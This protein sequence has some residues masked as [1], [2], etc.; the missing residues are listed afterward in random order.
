MNDKQRV[1]LA[2]KEYDNL[3]VKHKIDVDKGNISVGSVSQVNDKPSGEQSFVITDQYVSPTASQAE[4]ESVKEVTVLYRGS[5]G[6]DKTLEK[7]GDVYRD[8]VVN[9]SEMAHKILTSEQGN[10]PPQLV[11]SAETLKEA[12]ELYPNANFS[13]Y[14][15]SLGSMNAQYAV[16]DLSLEDSQRISGGYFFQGPNIYNVLTFG[17]QN[18]ATQLTDAG[19]LYNYVDDKDLVPIGYGDGKLSVGRLIPVLSK[20]VDLTAQHMWGG[21]QYD[22]FGNVLLD[23]KGKTEI[24]G[25]ETQQRISGLEGLK[26]KFLANG[27][28]LSSAQEIFLDASEAKAITLGYKQTVQA[29]LDG[30][31][32]WFQNDITNANELWSQTKSDAQHWGEHLSVIEELEALEAGNATER[33][34]VK[35]PVEEAE[36]SL[37]VLKA[38]EE[39]LSTLLGN[40]EKAIESQ[41]ALDKELANYLF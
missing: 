34:I 11:S 3:E 31:K 41:V 29:E 19:K 16:S 39:E 1:E 40:I 13:V 24:I 37:S 28:S 20:K 22:T 9:N 18:I 12:M 2:N 36:K 7:P 21:Y 26:K 14:G 6:L 4:R 25:F 8:W 23:A 30:L 27:G 32:K 15:H 35:E 10:P 33:S 17:Q 5:T 38:S